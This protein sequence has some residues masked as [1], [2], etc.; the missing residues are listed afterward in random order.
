M[1]HKVPIS[2]KLLTFARTARCSYHS[3]LDEQKRIAEKKEKQ[4]AEGKKHKNKEKVI[5]KDIKIQIENMKNFKL[6]L[7]NI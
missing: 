6:Q 2:S 3:H 7:I 5:L 1:P 4:E